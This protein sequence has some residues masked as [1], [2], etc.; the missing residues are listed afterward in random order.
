MDDKLLEKLKVY[1]EH[2][3]RS[4]SNFIETAALRYMEQMEMADDFEM[5]EILSNENLLKK[6]KSGS[7]DAQSMRG[8]FV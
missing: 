3:N 1:A 6:L 5:N 4:M 2:E 8:R 7:K